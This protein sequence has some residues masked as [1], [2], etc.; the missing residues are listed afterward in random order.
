M[1]EEMQPAQI[2]LEASITRNYGR[3][4][5]S[6]GAEIIITEPNP[7]TINEGY[8]V[9]NDIINGQ[10]AHYESANLHLTPPNPS[11]YDGKN[12]GTETE[13]LDCLQMF[14]SAAKGK[15]YYFITGGRY[16]KHGVPIWPEV[17]TKQRDLKLLEVGKTY[18]MAG[19]RMK[20]SVSGNP[21]VIEL[22]PPDGE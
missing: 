14:V 16:T 5:A 22:V 12:A 15:T 3:V 7:T 6:F 1:S 20:V 11:V 19:W 13:T 21:K 17:L 9:L 10:F 18:N 2:K 8:A 4:Q